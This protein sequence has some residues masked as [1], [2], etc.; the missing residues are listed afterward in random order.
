MIPELG[1]LM[2]KPKPQPSVEELKQA[3]NDDGQLKPNG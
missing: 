2:P 3:M 1:S